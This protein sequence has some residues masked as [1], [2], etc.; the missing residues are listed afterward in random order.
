MREGSRREMRELEE[1]VRVREGS[2]GEMRELEEDVRLR[3]GS[4]GQMKEL[5]HESSQVQSSLTLSSLVKS[6]QA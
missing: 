4:R 3:E 1:D 2:R 6:S 5:E